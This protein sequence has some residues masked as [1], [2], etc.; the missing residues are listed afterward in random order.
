MLY[1]AEPRKILTRY[2]PP[3]CHNHT[4]LRHHNTFFLA[5][6]RPPSSSPR[7]QESIHAT[8]RTL[9]VV[10]VWCFDPSDSGGEVGDEYLKR[11]FFF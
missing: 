5:H 4:N 7:K 2:P 3:P 10:A 6:C 11:A 9:P 8:Y 1:F